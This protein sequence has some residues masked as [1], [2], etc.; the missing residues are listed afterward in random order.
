MRRFNFLFPRC[1]ECG[2]RCWWM[3]QRIYRGRTL[4]GGL[5][6]GCTLHWLHEGT[7]P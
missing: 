4:L 3:Y 7:L 5:H 6:V 2:T 1:L